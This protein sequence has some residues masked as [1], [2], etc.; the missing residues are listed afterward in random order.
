MTNIFAH[1][2]GKGL[3]R[4]VPVAELPALL[5]RPDVHLWVDIQAPDDDDTDVLAEIFQFHP[6]AIEDCILDRPHPKVDEYPGYLYLVLH[7]VKV[8]MGEGSA[9]PKEFQSKELDVFLGER[10]LVTFHYEQMR[11]IDQT[12]ASLEKNP[13]R[14]ARGPALLLHDV[15][16]FLVDHYL[17]VMEELD[18]RID[19][20][21]EA[22]QKDT[23]GALLHEIFALRRDVMRIRRLAGKQ[24]EVLSRLARQ[25]FPQID[26]QSAVYYRN[27][28]D[29]LVRVVDLAESYRELLSSIMETFL[30]ANSNRLNTIM[31]T[32]TLVNTIFLPL[33]FVTG[34]YGMN[35]DNLPGK[36]FHWGFWITIGGMTAIA[37]VMLFLY[38]RKRWL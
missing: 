20:L 6:L 34:I 16:D 25:E 36:T 29:H 26:A 37:M 31:K 4:D 18:D 10:Y 14:L 21:E 7:G 17:P 3:R 1:V 22:V 38:R 35:F 8:T 23:T 2:R 30:T 15:L 27:V 24:R 11:S 28:H 5:Q 13:E 9:S 19:V 12:R 33:T 32:L